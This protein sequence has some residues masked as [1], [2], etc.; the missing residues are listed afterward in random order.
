MARCAIIYADSGD[1]DNGLVG[2]AQA[3]KEH[4]WKIGDKEVWGRSMWT[5]LPERAENVPM[6]IHIKR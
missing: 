6:W 2:W 5:D 4:D 3:W 1:V